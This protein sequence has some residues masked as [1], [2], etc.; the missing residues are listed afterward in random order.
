MQLKYNL[1]QNNMV[2]IFREAKNDMNT[3]GIIDGL[4][5]SQHYRNSRIRC[6]ALRVRL[7]EGLS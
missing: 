4:K 5:K 7:L 2:M 1:L 3:E 6:N